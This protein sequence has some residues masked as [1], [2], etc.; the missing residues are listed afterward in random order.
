MESE[1]QGKQIDKWVEDVGK[2]EC[3]IVMGWI[4]VEVNIPNIIRPER[5]L[6]YDG[7]GYRWG[8]CLAVQNSR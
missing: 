1:P 5:E 6:T 4:R 3:H 8:S 7:Y 2:S